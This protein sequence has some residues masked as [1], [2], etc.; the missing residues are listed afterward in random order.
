ML[1]TIALHF[2]QYIVERVI[3]FIHETPNGYLH[4]TIRL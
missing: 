4:I 2:Y 3:Y 1:I